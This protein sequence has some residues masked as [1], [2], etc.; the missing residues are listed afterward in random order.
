MN[1]EKHHD[2]CGHHYDHSYDHTYNSYQ[3]I[4]L[5][6]NVKLFVGSSDDWRFNSGVTKID[7]DVEDGFLYVHGHS[8]SI[9]RIPVVSGHMSGYATSVLCGIVCRI[10]A[11]GIYD[12]SLLTLDEAI[13]MVAEEH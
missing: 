4:K 7:P 6:D 1:I 8:G 5:A 2:K 13:E 10:A 11:A 3:F 12:Y 9:Y